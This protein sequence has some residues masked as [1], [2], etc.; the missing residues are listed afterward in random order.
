MNEWMNEKQFLLGSDI[1]TVVKCMLCLFIITCEQNSCC[2]CNAV[3]LLYGRVLF[4]ILVTSMTIK[5]VFACLSVSCI[6]A[7][8]T[9]LPQDATVTKMWKLK[10]YKSSSIYKQIFQIYINNSVLK[11][12]VQECCNFIPRSSLSNRRFWW[13]PS[14]RQNWIKFSMLSLEKKLLRA[15]FSQHR[16]LIVG[17]GWK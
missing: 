1:S 13:T 17:R 4:Q 8:A 14:F 10:F 6:P 12:P 7:D 3:H 9:I 5:G 15:A 11:V 2:T 16:P